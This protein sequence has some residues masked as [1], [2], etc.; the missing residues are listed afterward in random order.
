ML[1]RPFGN[2]C[3]GAEFLKEHSM[4]AAH[5]EFRK[6]RSR[7]LAG[8]ANADLDGATGF[9]FHR[10][11][12]PGFLGSHCRIFATFAMKVRLDHMRKADMAQAFSWK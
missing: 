4:R 2:L 1:T 8:P 11:S 9:L 6:I 7:R 3:C 5:P 12:A 10:A